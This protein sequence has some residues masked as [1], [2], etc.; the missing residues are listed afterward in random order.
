MKVAV[1]SQIV[2]N[3]SHK[4]TPQVRL[5]FISTIALNLV[6]DDIKFK[7]GQLN[8]TAAQSN[9]FFTNTLKY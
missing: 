3:Y 9:K 8:L 1:L 6:L 5:F 7:N 4:Y 2:L